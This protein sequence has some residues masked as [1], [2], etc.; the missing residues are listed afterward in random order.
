MQKQIQM[1]GIEKGILHVE[2]TYVA[3][4]LSLN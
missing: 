2:I 1:M 4:A 3:T